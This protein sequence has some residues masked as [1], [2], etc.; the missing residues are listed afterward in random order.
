MICRWSFHPEFHQVAWISEHFRASR[1][2]SIWSNLTR[3]GG[4]FAMVS[5]VHLP[6]CLG[7]FCC[8]SLKLVVSL[9]FEFAGWYFSTIVYSSFGLLAQNILARPSRTATEAAWICSL[10]WQNCHLRQSQSKRRSH[11]GDR[12][13]IQIQRIIVVGEKMLV[14]N[15]SKTIL[16]KTMY[17]WWYI[18]ATVDSEHY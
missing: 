17:H 14:T 18:D 3:N 7:S 16:M 12:N 4:R 13:S 8:D 2:I 15:G 9:L 1:Q 10:P 6:R 11:D 5:F